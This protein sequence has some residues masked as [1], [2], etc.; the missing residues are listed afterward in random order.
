MR[1]AIELI[2]PLFAQKGLKFNGVGRDLD[3]VA[4][5]DPERV[6]QILVNLLSNA[7][8]FTPSGGEIGADCGSTADTVTLRIRDTGIGIAA[9]KHEA[10]F[11][12][13]LQLKGGSRIVRVASGWDWR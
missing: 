7:I 2:E 1:H 3:I 9:E 4:H 11:E 12:P 6:T 10:I 13:F 5:A 8:K